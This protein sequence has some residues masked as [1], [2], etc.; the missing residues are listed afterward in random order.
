ML[1][2]T[3]QRSLR[4]SH[5]FLAV[6]VLIHA[7]LLCIPVATSISPKETLPKNKLFAVE[8]LTR[9]PESNTIPIKDLDAAPPALPAKKAPIQKRKTEPK[10]APA[11]SP[12]DQPR[13]ATVSLD[14][15]NEGDLQYRTYLGHLRS[16]ISAVWEYPPVARE[17]GLNGVVTVRFTI[18]R[19]GSIKALTVKKNS[20]HKLLDVEA[21]RTVRTAAPFMSFPTEFSIEKLNVSVSFVYEFNSD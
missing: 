9:E 8:L 1:T 4:S 11:K 7:V 10:T 14:R 6:S 3:L 20:P 19:N 18:A 21:L 5:I 17:K 16:K 13:E 2:T 12:P 15:L